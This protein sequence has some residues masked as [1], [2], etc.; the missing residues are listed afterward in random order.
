MPT[1]ALY[2]NSCMRSSPSESFVRRGPDDGVVRYELFDSSPTVSMILSFNPGC[3]R[4]MDPFFC[5]STLIPRKFPRS[6]SSVS[7]NYFLRLTN[8]SSIVF[9]SLEKK[10]QSSTYVTIMHSPCKNRH[11]LISFCT[12]PLCIR[13]SLSFFQKRW[14][15][16][17]RP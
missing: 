12:K 6:P 14:P 9:G 4:L 1:A 17:L 11:W 10:R 13:P 7:T 8:N 3:V 16:C 2:S 5:L 15:P